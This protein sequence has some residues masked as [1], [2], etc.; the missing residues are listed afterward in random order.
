MPCSPDRLSCIILA[1]G[2]GSRLDNQ[3]KGLLKIDGKM[4]I[5]QV[6][7]C[8]TQSVDDIVISA[9]RHHET[10]QQYAQTVVADR[11]DIAYQGPLAGIASC[12]PHCQ[13]QRVLVT[14]C[15]VPVLP[16]DLTARL[17]SA[18]GNSDVSV[19]DVNGRMQSIFILHKRCQQS[20]DSALQSGQPGLMR[21]IKQ[22]SHVTVSFDASSPVFL[23]INT[24]DELAKF[25]HSPK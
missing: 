24:E 2:R 11:E 4:L 14:S 6:I 25:S 23:N 18:L 12:L 17:L 5:E 16:Q 8:V 21:W 10:Y 22:Q 3:D 13:Q 1:G 9:N 15:D 19:C 20:I 7:S